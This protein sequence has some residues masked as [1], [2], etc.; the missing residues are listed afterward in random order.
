[1]RCLATIAA[2]LLLIAGTRLA[3]GEPPVAPRIINVPTADLQG[4]G[5]TFVTTG[6]SHKG[7][8]FVG[9]SM[10]LGDIAEVDLE[11]A[12]RAGACELCSGEDRHATSVLA[13]TALFK[14]GVAEGRF[15]AWQPALALGLRAPIGERDVTVDELSRRVRTAKLYLGLS[16]RAG[17][18][19]LHAGAEV[20]DASAAVADDVDLLHDRPLRQRVRPFAGLAW[21]PSIY[22]RTTLL[23]DFSSAPVFDRSAIELR[24]LGG[25]GV[26]YQAVSWASV[27]LGMRHRGGDS[28]SDSTVLVRVNAAFPS[29]L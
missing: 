20:W 27:E 12:D 21:N 25:W 4:A 17:P 28:L 15:A 2:P 7:K 1:M 13:V 11:V 10:G 6:V 26:R 23:A 3:G 29:P 16:K 22:P 18:V 8:P 14:I 9:L 19:R 24:W 5:R